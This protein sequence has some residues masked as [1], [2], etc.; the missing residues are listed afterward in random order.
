MTSTPLGYRDG[1]DCIPKDVHTIVRHIPG[2]E[3]AKTLKARYSFQN[4]RAVLD[5]NGSLVAYGVT[6]KYNRLPFGYLQD[7]VFHVFKPCWLAIFFEKDQTEQLVDF[8][9]P[10]TS[11]GFGK[12]TKFVIV[13]VDDPHDIYLEPLTGEFFE[14]RPISNVPITFTFLSKKVH[15]WYPRD[16]Q[17][18]CGRVFRKTEEFMHHLLRYLARRK[19]KCSLSKPPNEKEWLRPNSSLTSP[20]LAVGDKVDPGTKITFPMCYH[21]GPDGIIREVFEDERSPEIQPGVRLAVIEPRGKPASAVQIWSPSRYSLAGSRKKRANL[22]KKLKDL[23]AK[24]SYRCNR[25]KA[26]SGQ[27]CFDHECFTMGRLKHRYSY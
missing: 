23:A 17:C 11:V 2:S 27:V 15:G 24:I 19:L 18:A 8:Y 9:S 1:G 7:G 12:T 25:C 20:V 26:E 4:K 21:I 22:E 14:E 3:P 6:P 13:K 5:P 10:D 16:G